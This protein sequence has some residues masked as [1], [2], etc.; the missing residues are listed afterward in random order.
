VLHLIDRKVYSQGASI[1]M[2]FVGRVGSGPLSP[3]PGESAAQLDRDFAEARR[4][5]G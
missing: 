2:Q 3:E 1:R 5:L 4:L